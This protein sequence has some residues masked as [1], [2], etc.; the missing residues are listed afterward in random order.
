MARVCEKVILSA[1]IERVWELLTSYDKYPLW[2]SDLKM[3]DVVGD[4]YFME[5]STD[6]KRL[7][8]YII[9]SEPC[10]LLTIDFKND[11]LFGSW[12]GRL[13]KENEKTVLDITEE[14]YTKKLLLR[15]FIK[16]YLKKQQAV[17]IED[18]K[19]ALE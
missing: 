4:K 14:L 16:G 9:K 15:P 2:R 13:C 10:S 17:F 12:T 18:M 6:N 19:R 7:M 5:T 1:D 11:I 3:V 8:F